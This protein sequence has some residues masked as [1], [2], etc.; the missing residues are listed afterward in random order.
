MNRIVRF[1][2]SWCAPCKGLATIIESVKAEL[3]PIEVVDIDTQMDVAIN[4]RV[5]S[6]PTLIMYEGD[7]ETKRHTGLMT[8]DQL[9][10]WIN[11]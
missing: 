6:V 10:E 2:A 7:S 8:E 3:P 1:T 9:L 4:A 11:A 5:R